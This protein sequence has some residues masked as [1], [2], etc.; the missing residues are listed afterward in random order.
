MEIKIGG[1]KHI[2]SASLLVPKDEEAWLEFTADTWNVKIDI[3]FVD[4]ESSEEGFTIE[5]KDDHALFTVKNW[6]N[7]LP[8]AIE[9]PYGLGEVNSKKIVF[10]F[11]GYS[12]GSLKRMDFSF[13]WENQ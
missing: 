13:F 11:T 6:K 7:S 9:T 12:V 3:I 5:A 4:D 2:G 10:L 1:R 8:M